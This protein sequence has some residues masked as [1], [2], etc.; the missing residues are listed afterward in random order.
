MEEP[1]WK[2]RHGRADM[3]W[4]VAL[5]LL[6]KLLK[7]LLKELLTELLKCRDR[8]LLRCARTSDL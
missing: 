7:K 1:T 6:K 4:G 8:V 2:S 3:G 5:Q